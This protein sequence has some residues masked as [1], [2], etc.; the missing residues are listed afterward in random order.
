MNSP[1]FVYVYVLDLQLARDAK[2]REL[3]ELKKERIELEQRVK[4]NLEEIADLE[5]E[6][7]DMSFQI[8]NPVVIEE[9]REVKSD[10]FAQPVI[11]PNPKLDSIVESEVSKIVGPD[12]FGGSDFDKPF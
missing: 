11:V 3:R 2:E 9:K 4:E 1:S 7:K 5:K 12:S 8:Q 10:P 6:I